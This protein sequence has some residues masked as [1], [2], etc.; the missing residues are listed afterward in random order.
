[1]YRL[2]RR[3][4]RSESSRQRLAS[5]SVTRP[6]SAGRA[7]GRYSVIVAALVLV[8]GGG[9]VTYAAGKI[10][11]DSIKNGTVTSAD[12]TNFTLK[13]KD[14]DPYI[15]SRLVGP[16]AYS[17]VKNDGTLLNDS[18]TTVVSLVLPPGFYTVSATGIVFEVANADA[19]ADCDLDASDATLDGNSAVSIPGGGLYASVAAQGTFFAQ[20]PDTILTFRCLGTN[21]GINN[22]TLTAIRLSRLYTS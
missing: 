3:L 16:T 2:P 19:Y 15:T 21:A 7:R 6:G 9:G 4:R 5:D 17:T 20:T 8:L 13:R 11:G 18:F 12:I 10:T 14:L 1:M 22:V